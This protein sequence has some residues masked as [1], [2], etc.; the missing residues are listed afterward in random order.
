MLFFSLLYNFIK[1]FTI[2]NIEFCVC[3][4]VRLL[5]CSKDIFIPCVIQPFLFLCTLL[6]LIGKPASKIF[7][8]V[9]R[10]ELNLLLVSLSI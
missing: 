4:C 9:C 7:R 2:L 10:K 8:K 3:V 5:L 6:Y 1:N